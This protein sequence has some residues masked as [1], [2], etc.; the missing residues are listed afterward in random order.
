MSYIPQE[1]FG[2]QSVQA[3]PLNLGPNI[4]PAQPGQLPPEAYQS[5]TPTVRTLPPQ[6]KTNTLPPKVVTTRLQ[7]IYPP[8]GAQPSVPQF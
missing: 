3:E 4:F 5:Q 1:Q 2:T 6:Y 8:G 7:P